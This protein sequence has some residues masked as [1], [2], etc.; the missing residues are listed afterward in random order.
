MESAQINQ[1]TDQLIELYTESEDSFSLGYFRKVEK[2]F[3]IF[4]AVNE[5]GMLDSIQV[6]ANSQVSQIKSQT[7]YTSIFQKFINYNKKQELY[8]PYLLLD[9]GRSLLETHHL[10]DCFKKNGDIFTFVLENEDYLL[11]GQVKSL[12]LENQTFQLKLLD[13]EKLQFHQ[14]VTCH[15]ENIIAIDLASNENYLLRM[16]L[17]ETL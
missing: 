4:E 13:L 9:Q 11:K 14:E 8:D 6:R 12:N 7:S 17:E 15:F 2:E 10:A 1:Y 16:V 5:I 3:S